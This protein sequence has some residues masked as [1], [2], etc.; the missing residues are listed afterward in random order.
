MCLSLSQTCLVAYHWSFIALS[1]HSLF[2]SG[3]DKWTWL[4]CWVWV[5]VEVEESEC[6]SSEVNN[7]MYPEPL[8]RAKECSCCEWHKNNSF[9]SLWRPST[10]LTQPFSGWHS[11][12]LKL[13][14]NIVNIL[15]RLFLTYKIQAVRRF[16]ELV[17]RA[18]YQAEVSFLFGEKKK[19]TPNFPKFLSEKT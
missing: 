19:H 6:P 12:S 10:H 7:E 17:C 4:K 15:H 16:T 3:H 5:L 18:V 11:V 14:M 13:W 8:N 9:Q 2:I 1:V